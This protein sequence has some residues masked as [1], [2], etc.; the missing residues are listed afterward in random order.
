VSVAALEVRERERKSRT[1][2][3][4]AVA[5]CPGVRRRWKGPVHGGIPAYAGVSRFESSTRVGNP[6]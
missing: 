3:G 4:E 1:G 6:P 2:W 5:S